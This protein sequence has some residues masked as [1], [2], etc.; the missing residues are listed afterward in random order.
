MSPPDPSRRLGRGLGALLAPAPVAQT[1]ELPDGSVQRIPISD[2]QPNPFQPRKTFKPAELDELA[3]SLKASG[4][5]QPI[6][7][8]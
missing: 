8:R 7:Q 6:A 1:A 3:A 2:I 5:L 4:L